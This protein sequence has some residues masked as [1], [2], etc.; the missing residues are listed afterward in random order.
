MFSATFSSAEGLVIASGYGD[1][2]VRIWN[3]DTGRQILQLNLYGYRSSIM[4]LSFSPDGERLASGSQDGSIQLWDMKT[5]QSIVGPLRRPTTVTYPVHGIAFSADGKRV[6]SM[7]SL[8][9]TCL[10]W[11]AQTG[12]AVGDPLRSLDEETVSFASMT[13]ERRAI[14][15]HHLTPTSLSYNSVIF[16]PDGKHIAS[17]RTQDKMIRIWDI[18]TS[19]LVGDPLSGHDGIIWSISYAPD[20]T[21]LASGSEDRSVR[22]WDVQTRQTVLGP[23]RGHEDEIRSVAFSPNGR[24]IVSGSSD[25]AIRIWDAH[26]G[27]TVAGPLEGHGGP[28]GAFAVAFTPDSKHVISGGWGNLVKVW[29]AEI[30]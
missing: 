12:Q 18:V 22:V 27:Q 1:R 2:T 6:V 17:A 10:L 19:K 7:D 11:D 4:S 5:G 23:L 16:S 15:W 20:G 28:R 14:L 9:A 25:G 24:L 29:D 21:R 8:G 26:T 30:D 13:S 3:A